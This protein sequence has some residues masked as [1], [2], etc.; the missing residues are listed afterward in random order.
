[1]SSTSHI[2]N[3]V[4]FSNHWETRCVHLIQLHFHCVRVEWAWQKVSTPGLWMY[5]HSESNGSLDQWRFTIF[6]LHCASS[7]HCLQWFYLGVLVYKCTKNLGRLWFAFP[8]LQGNF[9]TL[10]LMTD[11]SGHFTQLELSLRWSD[12]HEIKGTTSIPVSCKDVGLHWCQQSLERMMG[13]CWLKVPNILYWNDSYS[14][15]SCQCLR[16]PQRL[17]FSSRRPQNYMV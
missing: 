3:E 14:E 17:I 1:M 16:K 12:L 10:Q 6:T 7:Q 8:E 4:I 15:Y 9:F 13:R 5:Y 2:C 11:D